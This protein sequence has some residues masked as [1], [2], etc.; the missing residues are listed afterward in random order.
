MFV[1]TE[2]A[3]RAVGLSE[4]ELRLGFRE[5][6]YPALEIG[7]GSRRRALRWDLD[8]LRAALEE[9]MRAPRDVRAER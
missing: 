5:G 3:A 2:E 4:Y 8:V 9:Q 7:R 6:K 1:C